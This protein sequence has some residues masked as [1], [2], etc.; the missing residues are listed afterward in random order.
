MHLQ[1]F[2]GSGHF[3]STREQRASHELAWWCTKTVRRR[4]A[5][6][7]DTDNG[8]ELMIIDAHVYERTTS[9]E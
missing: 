6:L 1:E 5:R 4:N 7:G 8:D 3:P 2:S 9:D